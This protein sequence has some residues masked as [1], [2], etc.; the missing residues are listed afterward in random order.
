MATEAL[1]TPVENKTCCAAASI[2]ARISGVRVVSAC[3]I[4]SETLSNRRTR[5]I[6]LRTAM[7]KDISYLPYLILR[8]SVARELSQAS[9][10]S[11]KVDSWEGTASAVPPQYRKNGAS[12]PED[13][14][15]TTV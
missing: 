2:L 5:P 10:S 4:A 12:A 15:G 1:G 13:G 11:T 6:R 3:A 9:V 14:I 7:E 8:R